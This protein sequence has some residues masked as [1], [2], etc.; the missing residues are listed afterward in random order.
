MRRMTVL[1][2]IV[3]APDIVSGG[4]RSI[5]ETDDE[6]EVLERFP[7]FG[8]VPDVVLYDA[9]GMEE[10][11]GAELKTLVKDQDWAVLVV[12]RDLR[13]DLAARALAHGAYGCFSLESDAAEILAGIHAAVGERDDNNGA[14]PEPSHPPGGHAEL[15]PREVQVLSGITAG[16]SNAE[17]CVLL[18][19]GHNTMKTYIRTAYRKIDVQTRAQAVAWCLQHGFEPP[20]S[21]RGG[22]RARLRA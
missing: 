3:A 22:L 17:I 16:L 11:D 8:V 6:I 9:V 2:A 18:G 15:S 21:D 4:L 10:D 20:A 14:W 12:G 7:D 1:V 19:L 13:P 5:V